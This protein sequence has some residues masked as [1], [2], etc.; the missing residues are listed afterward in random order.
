MIG[1]SATCGKNWKSRRKKLKGNLCSET[2][3]CFVQQVIQSQ[4]IAHEWNLAWIV[5]APSWNQKILHS[6][7]HGASSLS[8]LWR[9]PE[10]R[11]TV[12][13]SLMARDPA[14][15]TLGYLASPGQRRRIAKEVAAY[16]ANLNV[17]VMSPRS[18][19]TCQ[20]WPSGTWTFR[21][22]II[23]LNELVLSD[24]FAIVPTLTINGL[25]SFYP[26]P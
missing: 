23:W 2:F 26:W 16:V 14:C 1:K 11:K 15:S 3:S 13:G 17:F 19:P 9:P 20:Y 8:H 6:R 4:Q 10:G 24:C 12:E 18:G 5:T 25:F 21:C 22:F 7:C